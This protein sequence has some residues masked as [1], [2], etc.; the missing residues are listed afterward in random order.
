MITDHLFHFIAFSYFE[1]FNFSYFEE[2]DVLF[3]A[4]FLQEKL[5]T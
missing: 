1:N 5:N 4:E 2:T 3:R